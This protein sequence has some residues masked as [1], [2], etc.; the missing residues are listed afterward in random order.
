MNKHISRSLKLQLFFAVLIALTVAVLVFAL[1][2]TVGSLLLD[3]TVY[4][5]SFAMQ[6]ADTQSQK[7]QMFIDDEGVSLENLQRL[8]AWCNR[9]DKVYLAIYHEDE[10]VFDSHVSKT[11]YP[12]TDP[13]QEDPQSEYIL[14]LADGTEVR[15]F[16]YYYAGDAFYLWMTVISGILAFI[17][18]SLFFVFLVNKKVSYITRLQKELEILSGGQLEYQITVSGE[19]EL[20]ELALG[21]DQM[22]K[23]IIKHQETEKQMRTANSELITSM[24]HD[25]RTPLTSL[26]A[27]LEILER[28]KYAD[29]V[30]M[31]NLIHKSLG[32]TM[33]IRDMA[34]K[35]FQY[36]FVYATEWEHA[37]MESVDADMLFSQILEDYASALESQGMRVER[38]FSEASAN[39]SVN[40]DLLQ[41][42][43]DNLYSNLMKY[44]DPKR[45]VKFSYQ[46][47]GKK[48]LLTI[49]NGIAPER[50]KKDSTQIGLCTCRRIIE[51][52]NGTFSA[53]ENHKLFTVVIELPL[54]SNAKENN[55]G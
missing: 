23:S 30:Q 49:L 22:R 21:I 43:L 52:H 28:K 14:T 47:S 3:N 1:S 41:R 42:A 6:M 46:R 55:K 16:L 24:S 39:I 51:F 44:A 53:T 20:S 17:G 7:L 9:G 45:F 12:A 27:Y 50:E 29:E 34:D 5:H 11:V 8:K 38:N 2:F 35:L 32:Q 4:G 31:Q 25:L 33:R 54:T 10:L 26:L 15:A 18:F 19:D 37:E 48:L 36:F 40:T 13:E